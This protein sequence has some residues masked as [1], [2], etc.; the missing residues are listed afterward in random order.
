MDDLQW[1]GNSR[2]MYEAVINEIPAFFRGSVRRSIVKWIEQNEIHT[3]TEDL[4]FRAVDEIAP[5]DLAE[6]RIKPGL[7]ELRTRY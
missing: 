4:I 5:A 6:K 2:K 1:Q 3:V 7:E